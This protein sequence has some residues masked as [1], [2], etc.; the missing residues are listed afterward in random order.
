MAAR[1]VTRN[2]TLFQFPD[3]FIQPDV[4]DTWPQIPGM[5]PDNELWFHRARF[6][7]TLSQSLIDDV[8]EWPAGFPREFREALRNLIFKSQ[9]CPHSYILMRR[10]FD[11]KMSVILR[12]AEGALL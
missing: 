4:V 2:A 7:K 3:Q 1:R 6:A 5:G 9:G 10:N 11:V 8:F 12:S